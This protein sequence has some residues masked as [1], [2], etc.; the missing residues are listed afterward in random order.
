VSPRSDLQQYRAPHAPAAMWVAQSIPVSGVRW[1]PGYVVGCVMLWANSHCGGL[2]VLLWCVQDSALSCVQDS[3]RTTIYHGIRATQNS[4]GS[5]QT[6][7]LSMALE[8]FRVVRDPCS[9]IVG[10]AT[11]GGLKLTLP[12]TVLETSVYA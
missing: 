7:S 9:G 5:A 11:V 1:D 10:H 8:C 2:V 4:N 3:A 12:T 6:V